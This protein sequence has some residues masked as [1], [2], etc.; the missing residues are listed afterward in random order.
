[1]SAGLPNWAGA[2]A[3]RSRMEFDWPI[4]LISANRNRRLS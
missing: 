2:H 4:G 1:M 3:P